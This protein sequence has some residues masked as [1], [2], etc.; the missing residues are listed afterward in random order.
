LPPVSSLFASLLGYNPMASLLPPDVLKALP[1]DQA[2]IL[3]G[4]D[5]FPNLISGPFHDGLVIVF[6]VAAGMSIVA[7]IAS[8]LRGGKYVHQEAPAADKEPGTHEPA[9]APGP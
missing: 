3:T 8:A 5:F 9:T 7:A 4:K 1:P 2:A 6:L